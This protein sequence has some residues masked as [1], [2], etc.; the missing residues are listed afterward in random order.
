MC[1]DLAPLCRG[2]LAQAAEPELAAIEDQAAKIPREPHLPAERQRLAVV[3][4]VDDLSRTRLQ[5]VAQPGAVAPRGARGELGEQRR[6]TQPASDPRRAS[7]VHPVLAPG[8]AD[9][10]LELRGAAR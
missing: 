7:I 3:E 9:Q 8:G 5:V 1:G 10:A 2:S 6:P 4:G